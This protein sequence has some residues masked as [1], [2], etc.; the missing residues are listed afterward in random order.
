MLAVAGITVIKV[1]VE[2]LLPQAA[3]K[4]ARTTTVARSAPVLANLPMFGILVT[5]GVR[6]LEL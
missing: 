2:L 4:N 6:D 3:R 1:N 5:S